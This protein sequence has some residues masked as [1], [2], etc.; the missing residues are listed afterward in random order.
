MHSPVDP[1]G[2]RPVEAEL[3]TRV[4]RST[5]RKL[6]WTPLLC[7]VILFLVS[8]AVATEIE[9]QPSH[10]AESPFVM[11][12]ALT[13]WGWLLL[14]RRIASLVVPLL[15][16]TLLCPGCGEEIDAVDVWDCACGFH[17]YRE[18]HILAGRC[19]SCGKAAGHVRCPRCDCTILLW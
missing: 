11:A 15:V 12:L 6:Y 1:S 9:G 4:G 16:S 3:M 5:L 7:I 2:N 10:P 8:A 18:R 13:F 17:D 19:S 14:G